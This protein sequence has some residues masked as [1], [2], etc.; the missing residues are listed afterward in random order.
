MST[1]QPSYSYEQ[2]GRSVYTVLVVGFVAVL[3]A[4]F[5]FSHDPV[6]TTIS[7]VLVILVCSGIF[8]FLRGETWSMSI[9][10]GVLSWA[11]ARWPKSSGRISLS[12]VRAIVIDDCSSSLTITFSDG[13]TRKVRLVGHAS[14]LR[15]YLMAHHPEIAVEYVE[16]T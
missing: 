13:S 8:A 10:D 14:R 4:L 16:G 1:V 2:K 5:F 3:A 6:F 12:T 7:A 15:D 9:E 11:Y